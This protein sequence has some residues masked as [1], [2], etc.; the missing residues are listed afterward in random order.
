MSCESYSPGRFLRRHE[1]LPDFCSW[2]DFVILICWWDWASNT[3]QTGFQWF[4][5][6]NERIENSLSPT[7]LF[8]MFTPTQSILPRTIKSHFDTVFTSFLPWISIF[9]IGFARSIVE[10]RR[11]IAINVKSLEWISSICG[12]SLIKN[13]QFLIQNSKYFIY[14]HNKPKFDTR[15]FYWFTAFRLKMDILIVSETKM[16]LVHFDVGDYF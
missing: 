2:Y 7:R 6:T 4:W 16:M 8:C 14:S 5:F 3:F 9:I 1:K 10:I 13:G 11:T 12:P 15:T